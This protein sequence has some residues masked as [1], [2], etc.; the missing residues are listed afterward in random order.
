LDANCR[1]FPA[2]VRYAIESA[3]NTPLDIPDMNA[4]RF[5][6]NLIRFAPWSGSG[7]F[8]YQQSPVY[9]GKKQ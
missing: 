3:T 7:P 2:P 4:L 9:W 5:V 6:W 8:D 1:K